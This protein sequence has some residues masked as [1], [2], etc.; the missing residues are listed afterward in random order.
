[1]LRGRW[2]PTGPDDNGDYPIIEPKG[3]N[4]FSATIVGTAKSEDDAI[5]MASA[6][7]LLGV[8]EELL[9]HLPPDHP[10]RTDLEQAIDSATGVWRRQAS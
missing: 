1:M 8:L 4:P 2:L 10:Q 7:M 3:A 5:L 9:K 6:P